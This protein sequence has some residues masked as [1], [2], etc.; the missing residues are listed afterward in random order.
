MFE[1][2]PETL[3]SS[4]GEAMMIWGFRI[5]ETS[6]C[7][8]KAKH[9]IFWSYASFAI[10]VLA[11]APNTFAKNF[12]ELTCF[13]RICW[14]VP[15]QELLS[16]RIG[17]HFVAQAS[18]YDIAEQDR[19]N[20]PGLTSSGENFDPAALDRISSPNL[21]NGTAVLLWSPKSKVA[22]HAIVNNTGPFIGNRVIDVPVGLARAMGFFQ[23]GLTE[24][25]VV[26][27]APPSEEGAGYKKDRMY[28]FQ[29]GILGNFE[30]MQDAVASLS[31][32]ISA[33]FRESSDPESLNFGRL[34]RK[35]KSQRTK[36]R[37]VPEIK[38]KRISR[39]AEVRWQMKS[40][41]GD[42]P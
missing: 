37:Q 25:H 10:C 36:R 3:N 40:L 5:H 23:Q 33:D 11:C 34:T 21:P 9:R 19:H 29:G 4:L 42:G 12:G 18:W 1:S 7:V 24:L 13:K 22:A 28:D 38:P 15:S 20:R 16:A 27:V 31:T 8:R 6:E 32:P 2:F 30:A 41:I 17:V 39:V 35:P 14:K 26:I